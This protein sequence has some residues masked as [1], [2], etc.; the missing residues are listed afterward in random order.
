LAKGISDIREGMERRRAYGM[1]AVWPWFLVLLA[2]AYGKVGQLGEG[3]AALRE[4]LQ[5]VQRNDERLY[6]AEVYRIKGELLL[7]QDV[8]DMAEAEQ[9]FQRALQVARQ[10]EA[11]SWELRA[12]TSLSRLWQQEGK[13]DDTGELLM[14][15]YGW[16]TEGFDTADLQDVR[17]LAD[18]LS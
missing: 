15:V 2:E 8:P 14:P 1:G 16:F 11:K 12:A 9:C 5:W 7:K 10:Q 4:A 3:L 18:R 17:D 6:E 13:R